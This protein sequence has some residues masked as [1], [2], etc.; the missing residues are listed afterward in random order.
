MSATD[1]KKLDELD[2][3]LDDLDI[4]YTNDMETINA[5]GGVPAGFKFEGE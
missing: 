1:K 4:I 3:T 5:V 2:K